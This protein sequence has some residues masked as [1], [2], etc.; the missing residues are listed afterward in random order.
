GEG[1]VGRL[2]VERTLRGGLLGRQVLSAL[3]GAARD[4]GDE[5]VVLHAQRSAEGFYVRLGFARQGEPFE[6]AGIPHITMA[7]PLR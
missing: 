6:E 4:R 2:A 7:L 1:S 3:I 5:R